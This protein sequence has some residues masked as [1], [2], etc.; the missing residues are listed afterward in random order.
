M[1]RHIVMVRFKENATEAERAAVYHAVDAFANLPE[2]Q[3]LNSGV[4]VGTGPNN[5]DFAV[6]MDFED[7][8]AFR[9]YMNSD[10]HQAYVAGP[11][12]AVAK[13]AAIQV[14]I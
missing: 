14:E 2:V 12:K 11:A 5:H 10:A 4:N 3:S 7:M 6:V 13:L 9:R 8:D 1:L